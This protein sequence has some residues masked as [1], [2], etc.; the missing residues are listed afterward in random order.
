MQYRTK[1]E[2]DRALSGAGVVDA[3]FVNSIAYKW[4]EWAS[5]RKQPA[6]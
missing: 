6:A 2:I 1:A 5:P 4:P 3:H